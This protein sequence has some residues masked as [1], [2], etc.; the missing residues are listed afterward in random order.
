MSESSRPAKPKLP[1]IYVDE[2]QH[3]RD[4]LRRRWGTLPDNPD[5]LRRLLKFAGLSIEQFKKTTVYLSNIEQMPW[6]KEL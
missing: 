5:D 4:W 3:N 2:L 1:V 6:L